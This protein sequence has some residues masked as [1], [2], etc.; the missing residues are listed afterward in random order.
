[1]AT[2]S[3][4]YDGWTSPFIRALLAYA[5]RDRRFARC[6]RSWR[7][8]GTGTFGPAT[9]FTVGTPESVAIGDFNVRT[10]LI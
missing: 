4:A 8:A 3:L 7:R 5:E 2:L 10:L 9:N 6:F 1:V